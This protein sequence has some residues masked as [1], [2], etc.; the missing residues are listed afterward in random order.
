MQD[1][2]KQ[3]WGRRTDDEMTSR[4]MEKAQNK[5]FARRTSAEPSLD[6][7]RP[8]LGLLPELFKFLQFVFRF[9]FE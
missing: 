5:R 9:E 6:T 1:N 7:S 8:P 3:V 2:R 4:K